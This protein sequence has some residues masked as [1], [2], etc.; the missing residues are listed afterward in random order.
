M[1]TADSV[2]TVEK[3]VDIGTHKLNLVVTEIPSKFTVVLEAGGGE[4][5]VS[6]QPIQEKLAFQI[7]ARIISYDRSGFGKS[8]L[9]PNKFTAQDEC[10]ALKTALEM[11][12]IKDNIIF[13]GLSYGGFLIQ[14]F[15][16]LFPSLVKGLVLIDPMN[17]IFVDKFGLEQ[18]NA[19][20]PYF[21]NPSNNAEK[22]GN[23]MT[24]QFEESLNFLR[25]KKLP[26]TIPV[27]LLSAEIPIEPQFWRNSHEQL[28]GHSDQHKL[29][30]AHK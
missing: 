26:S 9:G 22:A 15:T 20:T 6:Y 2:T 24:D 7:Q 16:Q 5:S 21:E 25:G 18:L 10:L 28:I 11:L 27:H 3:M 29:F 30:V 19:V 12:G 13:A 1:K 23:R 14:Y 4:C 8:E 17:V